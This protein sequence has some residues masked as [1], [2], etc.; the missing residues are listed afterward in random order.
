MARN[1]LLLILIAACCVDAPAQTNKVI[2]VSEGVFRVG[3]V[4]IQQEARTALLD[5][6]LNMTNGLVEYL[7]VTGAGKLHES[8]FRTDA[9]PADLHVA[10][11]L[12]GVKPAPTNL[13]PAERAIGGDKIWIDVKHGTNTFPVERLVWNSLRTNEMARGPWS[14]NGAR[15]IERTFTADRD[16]LFVS[17][18]TDVDALINNPRPER[19]NDEA[20]QV[21][22]NRSTTLATNVTLLFKLREK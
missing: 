2:Q 11:L 13:P 7:L 20:W 19:S 10:M 17:L 21:N 12:L 5:A 15:L 8:V 16:G 4:T 22:T 1:V 18:I 3:K 14:Y 6:T 9:S